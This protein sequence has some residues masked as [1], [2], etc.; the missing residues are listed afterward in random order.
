MRFSL[1]IYA[2]SLG[3]FLPVKIPDCCVRRIRSEGRGR[4]GLEEKCRLIKAGRHQD[5]G[6][7]LRALKSP[8]CQE[9]GS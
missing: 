3:L 4:T 5:V 8:E 2:N 1:L 7:L 6:D 9:F